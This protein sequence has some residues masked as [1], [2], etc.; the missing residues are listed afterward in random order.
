L[1]ALGLVPAVAQQ[2]LAQHHGLDG[3]QPLPSVP[4]AGS[5][6]SAGVSCGGSV[7]RRPAWPCSTAAEKAALRLRLAVAQRHRAGDLVAQF[8]DVARPGV[9][10]QAG[11]RSVGSA[12]AG[13]AQFGGHFTHQAL[14]DGA[15]VAGR[16][17]S[18]GTVQRHA[19]AMR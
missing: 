13:A 8:T 16:S 3:V 9:A 6:G 15:D 4:L 19:P 10:H 11:Q 17:R 2:G 1:A 14:G 5:A 12:G 18:G 7:P